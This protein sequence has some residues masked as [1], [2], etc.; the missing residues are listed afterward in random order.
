VD[1]LFRSVAAQYGPHA[2]AVVLTGMGQDGLRGSEAIRQAG[3]RILVQ[4]EATS[5]V[6]R[7]P[8]AVARAGLAD[9]VVPL[10][11]IATELINLTSQRRAC[12]TPS[13]ASS[14]DA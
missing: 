3:G 1:V 11:R 13:L 5:I 7:M 12:P 8:G 6:W 9:V 2:L 10:P 4:D 14:P